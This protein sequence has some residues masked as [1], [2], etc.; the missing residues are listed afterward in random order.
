MKHPTPY[1]AHIRTSILVLTA[2][3]L[4]AG[5][6][7]QDLQL[8][9]NKAYF[10][11][12]SLTKIM[13]LPVIINDT[14]PAKM[15]FDTG[16][17]LNS[18]DLDSAFCA[19][20]PLHL[21]QQEPI[22]VFPRNGVA[23]TQKRSQ[24]NTLGYKGDFTVR[25]GQTD[26]NYKGLTVWN[27]E[28]YF[29]KSTKHGLFNMP[30][31]DTTHVW[32]LNFEH[33]YIEL[34]PS[35]AF[36]PPE[37]C[38][39]T[40]LHFANNNKLNTTILIKITTSDGDTLTIERDFLIDS[41]MGQDIMI[42]GPTEE[43]AFFEDKKS[44]PFYFVDNRYINRHI[45]D[46]D[47]FDGFHID[48]LRIYT[49][50]DWDRLPTSYLVGLN[51]LKRFNVFID[52]KG[53]RM[54]LQPLKEFHRAISPQWKYYCISTSKTENGTYLVTEVMDHEYNSYKEAGIRV[55][56][57]IIGLNGVRLTPETSLEE[58]RKLL[59]PSKVIIDVLRDGKPIRLTMERDPNE[60]QDD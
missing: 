5:C 23:W 53:S 50:K 56:D 39:V 28:A 38:L 16:A 49:L 52:L 25:I 55:G 35:T 46:A 47:I 21:W 34:H 30:K 59:K 10:E 17:T 60:I 33:N 42:A 14:I 26:V 9:P 36:L 7:T 19:K 24:G 43:L 51:F 27:R 31:S 20:H 48:S 13:T 41:G 44:V 11:I 29:G 3:I 37:G 32:E 12:D 40:S 4:T 15:G 8:D 54:Y 57:E 58:S 45:V 2:L 18:F 6:R 22:A 1:S